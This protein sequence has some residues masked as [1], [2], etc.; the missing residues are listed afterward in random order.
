MTSDDEGPASRV[1]P[2]LS[3]ET[4]LI[5][6][7][8]DRAPGAP[9]GAT[10]TLAST[11]RQGGPLVY[12]RFGNAGWTEF[13]TVLGALEGGHAVA[14][15]SGMAA[16]SAV[17]ER[18][19]VGGTIVAWS[20]IYQGT[21]ALLRQLADTGR[22]RWTDVDPTD[23]V[24]LRRAVAGAD[25]LWLESPTNPLLDV[26]DVPRA[27]RIAR[28]AGVAVA[29]DNTFA[30]PLLQ[31]PLQAGADYSLHSATKL[32]AGHS[33]AIMGAVVAAD[34]ERQ[35]AIAAHRTSHGAVPGTLETFLALRGI[36]TLAVRLERVQAS[37]GVLAERLA[38][39][40]AVERVRY[41]GLADDPGHDV[42]RRT[43]A[44]FGGVVSF[45]VAGGAAGA[46]AVVDALQLIV[47]AT[48][49]GGVETLIER[50]ARWPTEEGI[51]AGLLR[52]SVGLEA[53]EDLWADLAGALDAGRPGGSPRQAAFSGPRS[54]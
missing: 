13:E 54:R 19:P 31:R 48:S 46:D 11:Y 53:L 33:D 14:F 12:G 20:R 1:A 2:H 52:M 9:L 45:E 34:A 24:A 35:A 36:R 37:A 41:P 49:L 6:A 18:V 30:T 40:P 32:L 44:G 39:H 26:I 10:L 51:P 3:P 25:L 4:V 21:R 38:A 23:D 43:M 29:V 50:R 16:V 8:R 42:A 27:I 28:E 7:G 22:L 5:A 15:A 17:V 47:P